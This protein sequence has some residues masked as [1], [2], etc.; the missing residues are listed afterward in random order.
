MAY[1]TIKVDNIT[2]TNGGSDQTITVSGIVQSISGNITATGT[3][4]GATIIG[5]STVSGAT[6][7]G[8]VGNFTAINGGTATLTSGVIASGTAA[9]PSLSIVGDSNTGLYSPGADQLAISTGGTGR[10]FVDASGNIQWNGTTDK[11]QGVTS[12]GRG[13]TLQDPSAPT[14]SIWDTTDPSYYTNITQLNDQSWIVNVA[15][16]PLIFGTSGNERMRLT[17]DG[18]LGLGTNSPTAALHLGGAPAGQAIR[19]NTNTNAGYIGVVGNLTQIAANRNPVDGSIVNTGCATAFINLEAETGNGNIQF[20]TTAA[21]NTGP[22]ERMRLTSDGKVGIGTSS[23]SQV[24]HVNQTG[25]VGGEYGIRISQTSATA[26]ALKILIDSANTTSSIMQ[27]S[28]PPLIFGIN[29]TE[30]L[31]IDSSGRLLVGTSSSRN[32]TSLGSP[33]FQIESIAY[34]QS[35][36]GL[37]NNQNVADGS[38]II[39]NKTRGTSVG[40]NTIVQAG[41]FLGAIWFQGTD[42]SASVLSSTIACA[43][44]GTPAANKIASRLVFSTTADGASAPTERLRIT[45]DGKVGIG[46]NSIRGTS[47]LDARGD[48]SFGSNATYYGLLGYNAGTGHVECTSSDG[49]FKWIRAS[50]AATS[51]VLDSSGRLLV[52]TSSS[53]STGNGQFAKLQ[54]VGNTF[55]AS[56][57]AIFALVR[58]EAASSITSDEDIASIG[59]TDN[60]GGTFASISCSADANAGTSDYPG[61]LVFSTTADGASSPTERMRI[62]NDGSVTIGN[63]ASLSYRLGLVVPSG[64]DQT[65]FLAG[66]SGASNGLQVNWV[67]ATTGLSVK[68]NNI[69]TTASAANAF[70]DSADG[71][72]IYRSTSSLRYKQDIE[73]IDQLHADAILNLRPIWYRSK[74]ADD[75]KDWSWYGLIAEEVA[76]VEPRLVHWTY[77]DDDYNTETV[78]G[79][80]KKTPKDGAQMVPDGV[81]YDRLTV[82]LL[83]VVKRQQQAIETLEAKVAALESA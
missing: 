25:V 3:I 56:N 1:G 73:D 59:F 79:E 31:R 44:E 5:T 36:I 23:P 29:N 11:T 40:S 61:R 83:D 6:V 19:I 38:Y 24:L 72:R 69:T 67:H 68:F 62:S 32:Y 13:I 77:L 49:A 4:Q 27:E 58:G 51:M 33:Q 47:L 52:G 48:I 8:N 35:S 80:I 2:F 18:K 39:F 45:S 43:V 9:N 46:T 41:D 7:T 78:N 22:T 64:A 21:N 34:A 74:A 14:L 82:L 65:V 55:N 50:G 12:S 57:D 54:I 16:G 63:N 15:S 60:A 71:N 76:K 28:T 20:A 53:L 30:R 75:R 26:N 42:G 81:Q 70:L 66:V 10:L 37:T 17:S